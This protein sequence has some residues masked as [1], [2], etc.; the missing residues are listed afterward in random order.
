M[1]FSLENSNSKKLG[2]LCYNY[3]YME[4]PNI[5]ERLI[6]DEE[7]VTVL[8]KGFDNP[9]T[10]AIYNKWLDQLEAGRTEHSLYDIEVSLRRAKVYFDAGFKN[11]A[12]ADLEETLEG[13]IGELG[14]EDILVTEIKGLLLKMKG[15]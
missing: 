1:E 5:P 8:K 13:T 2:G 14:E 6:M 3:D 11:E 15:E 7:V 4:T 12:I 9:E 10:Q